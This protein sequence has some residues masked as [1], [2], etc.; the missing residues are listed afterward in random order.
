MALTHDESGGTDEVLVVD[1]QKRSPDQNLAQAT[2]DVEASEMTLPAS[3]RVRCAA[4]ES[5][6][7]ES[8]RQIM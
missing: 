1:F 4:L 3:A 7:C 8:A 6:T 5:W 2:Q